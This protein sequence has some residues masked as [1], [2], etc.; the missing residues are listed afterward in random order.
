MTAYKNPD[1]Q[2]NAEENEIFLGVGNQLLS[3]EHYYERFA[4]RFHDAW[5][6]RNRLND[7]WN[8]KEMA[9]RCIWGEVNLSAKRNRWFVT[10]TILVIKLCFRVLMKLFTSLNISFHMFFI[11]IRNRA[12]NV[13]RELRRLS[14]RVYFIF[15]F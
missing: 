15:K 12:T 14:A 3:K 1:N 6:F 7:H 11:S 5:L 10:L 9:I 8:Q 2:I 4:Q 13:F